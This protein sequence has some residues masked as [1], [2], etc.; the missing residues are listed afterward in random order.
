[1]A[2]PD[3]KTKIKDEVKRFYG[4]K[5]TPPEGAGCCGGLP[6][7]G[8]KADP[9]HYS[10]RRLADLPKGL[11][12]TSF[13]CGNPVDFM[14]IKPGETVL[15]LGCGTGLD[16]FLAANKVGSN[17]RVIGVDMTPAMIARA[18]ANV[19]AVGAANIE[20]RQGEME[21]LPVDDGSVDWV[22]SNCVVNLSPDKGRVFAEIFRVLRPGGRMLVSDI[23]TIGQLSEAVRTDMR[24][25]AGC[26]AG[27]LDEGEFLDQ[28]GIAGLAEVHVVDRFLYDR[29]Q[30][31]AFISGC[32]SC[33]TK[34]DAAVPPLES[35]AGKIASA[36][37]F[38]R[39]PEK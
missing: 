34:S 10:D 19:A 27:A 38:A 11:T 3:D 28:A 15:D 25:W 32:C 31:T 23:V 30:L 16:L 22:M 37:I 9:A 21:H 13:G 14:K 12:L 36:K 18:R 35:L 1:M 26:I 17:G 39:K 20:V 24:L 33:G 5:V 8:I 2:Q 6:P 4:E 29:Q 7:A